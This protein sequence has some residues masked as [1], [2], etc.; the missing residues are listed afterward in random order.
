MAVFAELP[1]AVACAVLA[2]RAF[3]RAA[4]RKSS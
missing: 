2:I 4:A 3:P 1:L